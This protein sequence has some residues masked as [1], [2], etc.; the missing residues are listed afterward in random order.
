MCCNMAPDKP[1]LPVS[2]LMPLLCSHHEY[3]T[4]EINVNCSTIIS[5]WYTL[6]LG[7]RVFKWFFFFFFW[8]D[9]FW[10]EESKISLLTSKDQS[11]TD[12]VK[13][14][15]VETMFWEKG[16][17]FVFRLLASFKRPSMKDVLSPVLLNR[18]AGTN[19]FNVC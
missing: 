14:W 8:N 2:L 16:E 17:S 6:A 10:N 19:E 5:A 11:L 3:S 13:E 18:C 12:S 1:S 9:R 15:L 7:G 4:I